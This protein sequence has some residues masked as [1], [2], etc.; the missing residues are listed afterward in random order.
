MLDL[1]VVWVEVCEVW[2]IGGCEFRVEKEVVEG[3]TGGSGVGC[4]ECLQAAEI[5][6]VDGGICCVEVPL[7]WC[8]MCH[9]CVGVGG[10][11][12]QGT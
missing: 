10:L 9:G 3:L 8:C 4:L 5:L 12:S 6:L 11:R 7:G 2:V 1:E